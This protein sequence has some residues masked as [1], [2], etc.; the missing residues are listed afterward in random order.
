MMGIRIT[1]FALMILV[2]PYGWYTG[3]FAAA[4]IV[5]PYIAVVIANVSADMT[6]PVAQSPER[7]IG[8]PESPTDDAQGAATASP[9]PAV[10]RISETGA[11]TDST[12]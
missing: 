7:M 6:A 3:V 5:L 12:L 11:A 10:I 9:A 4:A 2:T 1:G 8:A